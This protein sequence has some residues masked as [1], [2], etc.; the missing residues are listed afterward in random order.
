MSRG[1]A[2]GA[3]SNI[4]FGSILVA[5]DDSEGARRAVLVAIE[6]AEK[7]SASLTI[8]NVLEVPVSPYYPEKEVQLDLSKEKPMTEGERIVLSAA[9]MAESRGVKTRLEVLRHMGHSTAEG[10]VEYARNNGIDLIVVG[11]SGQTGLKA[12]LLESVA[13][14]VV[15][16]AHCSVLLAR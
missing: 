8:L 11:A 3:A 9:E 13:N 16:A 14:D 2:T 5:V 15:K 7:F 4:R 12:V 6:E 1:N 10:I